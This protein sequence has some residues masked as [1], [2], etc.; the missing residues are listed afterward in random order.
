MCKIK[1][2]VEPWYDH[3]LN[4]FIIG[5]RNQQILK[6]FKMGNIESYILYYECGVPETKPDFN[7]C[8]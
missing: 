7:Q 3:S 6:I 5:I 1:T 4:V 2:N 8:L